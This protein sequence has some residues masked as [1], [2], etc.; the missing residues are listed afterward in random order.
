MKNAPAPLYDAEEAR[1]T[2]LAMLPKNNNELFNL[3]LLYTT[4]LILPDQGNVDAGNLKNSMIEM[5]IS[6]LD[7]NGKAAGSR[8]CQDW[9]PTELAKEPSESFSYEQ[10]DIISKIFQAYNSDTQDYIEGFDFFDDE[11]GLSFMLAE[12]W[13]LIL[14]ECVA[15]NMDNG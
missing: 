12:S 8:I 7:A 11:C 15:R 10:R 2:F 3:I 9:R 6:L 1:S 13:R 5:F 4:V 14:A